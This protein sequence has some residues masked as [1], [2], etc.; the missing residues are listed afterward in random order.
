[1]ASFLKIRVLLFS[2]PLAFD[3]LHAPAALWQVAY[4]RQEGLQHITDV[5]VNLE[6][7]KENTNPYPNAS[8]SGNS[9]SEEL[10]RN[11][12]G[13]VSEVR[14]RGFSKGGLAIYVL[15]LYGHD[16]HY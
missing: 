15:L 4:E 11:M 12:L 8:L 16:Y 1:M 9:L 6:I 14:E 7:Q 5:C 3:F 13:K 10:V 2:R